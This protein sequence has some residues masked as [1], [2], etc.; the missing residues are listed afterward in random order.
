VAS[1]ND[2]AEAVAYVAGMVVPQEQPDEEDG[3][4]DNIEALFG[5]SSDGDVLM[6]ATTDEQVVLMA[7]FDTAHRE[8]GTCQ[9]MA[10]EQD[11]L[12]AM[13]VVRANAVREAARV[14]AQAE[15]ARVMARVA[16]A[17]AGL[18]AREEATRV[19]P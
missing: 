4:S 3:A 14:A 10:A 16:E 5:D 6:P 11:T 9:F 17:A 15:A 1:A 13:L 8:E 7:S 2:A 18:A 19:A 12:A